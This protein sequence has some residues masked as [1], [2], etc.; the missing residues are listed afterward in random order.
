MLW[1]LSGLSPLAFDENERPLTRRYGKALTELKKTAA[2]THTRVD[3]AG[4][5]GLAFHAIEKVGRKT[6][7]NRR[8]ASSPRRIRRP[9][10]DL[11][12]SVR[13]SFLP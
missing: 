13:S 10:R 12:T 11:M 4:E 6:A 1:F 3:E 7:G 8:P 2:Q 9:S 5:E